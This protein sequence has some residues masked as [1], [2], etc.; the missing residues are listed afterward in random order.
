MPNRNNLYLLRVI[1]LIYALLNILIYGYKLHLKLYRRNINNSNDKIIQIGKLNETSNITIITTMFKIPKSKHS[2]KDYKK[3]SAKFF[4]S[5]GSPLVA[6]VDE[7]WSEIFIK[8]CILRNLNAFIFIVPNIWKILMELEIKRNKTYLEKYLLN[9]E[10]LDPDK[11]THSLE[12]YAIWNL[13]LYLLNKTAY[14][15]PFDSKFFLFTDSGAWRG[16][17]FKKW[18]DHRFIIDL[19]IKLNDKILFGQINEPDPKNFS[20]FKDLIQGTFFFGSTQAIRDISKEYYN[21]HDEWLDKGWFIGKEQNLLNF[22]TY[23]KNSALIVKLNTR[24]FNCKYKYDEWFFYQYYFAQIKDFICFD[25][26]LSI[27]L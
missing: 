21:L 13:K 26:K 18:P 20:I 12:L 22:L 4:S 19:G 8:E 10:I 3:W 6:Y 14:L 11:K 27:L 17:V 2:T 1:L 25:D 9:Q 5:L 15:N 23:V 24:L 16:K 7:F